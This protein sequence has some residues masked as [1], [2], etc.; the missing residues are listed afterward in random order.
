MRRLTYSRLPLRVGRDADGVAVVTPSGTERFDQIILA[1]HADQ[2]LELLADAS[3]A[4]RDILSAMPYQSNETVLHWDRSMLPTRRRAWAAWNYRLARG[5]ETKANVT[6]NLSILQHL[7]TR[8]PVCVTLNQT[9][10]IDPDK[11]L[12]RFDYHHP[13]YTAGGMRA[14]ERYAA[15]GGVNNTHF[16]GAYWFNGFHEDGVRSALRVCN[17][18]GVSL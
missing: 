13:V 5:E 3:E 9:D 12:A 7:Q 18:F 17:A 15:I 10:A 2:T 1:C 8:E 6:Y 16:C 11:I 14:R 4:E